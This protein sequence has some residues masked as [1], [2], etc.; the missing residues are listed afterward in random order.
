MQ[1]D[2]H[3]IAFLGP[4]AAGK[5]SIINQFT[6]GSFSD[7]EAMTVGAAFATAEI[8]TSHGYVSL[9]IWDTAGQEK[10]RSL[11]P[12]YARGSS[13]IIVVFDQGSVESYAQAQE[14][15]TT[16]RT[17]YDNDTCWYL[18][19]NKSDCPAAVNIAG[20]QAWA[21][22]HSLPFVQTSAKTG[23]NVRLLFMTVAEDVQ[24]PRGK[25]SVKLPPPL[26]EKTAEPCC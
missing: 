1:V 16:E 25:L 4:S 22:S 21:A 3:K 9:S 17:N 20:V 8:A 19:A 6:S 26:V 13:A 12:R 18:V 11:T 10:F 24:K 23:E 14:I 5:T 15:V 7:E 2:R